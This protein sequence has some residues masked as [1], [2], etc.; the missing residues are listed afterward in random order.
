MNMRR[1]VWIIGMVVLASAAAADT[2]DLALTGGATLKINGI[3]SMDSHVT[4]SAAP[5]AGATNVWV[6]PIDSHLQVTGVKTKDTTITAQAYLAYQ[7]ATGISQPVVSSNVA[8][9]LLQ[10]GARNWSMVGKSLV[11]PLPGGVGSDDWLQID[12]IRTK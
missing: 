11:V 9:I 12:G 6:M 1:M 7:D 4:I 2:V 10:G 3:W 8:Q 5:P